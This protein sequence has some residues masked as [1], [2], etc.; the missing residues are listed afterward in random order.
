MKESR[1]EDKNQ[2]FAF[3]DAKFEMPIRNLYGIVK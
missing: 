3:G 1:L 2:D